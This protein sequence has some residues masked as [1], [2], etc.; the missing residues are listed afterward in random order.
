MFGGST[1]Y[2]FREKEERF[3][4]LKTKVAKKCEN[5]LISPK[6]FTTALNLS[7]PFDSI[8]FV[9]THAFI[10]LRSEKTIRQKSF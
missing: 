4:L 3:T 1:G 5:D 6:R 2:P 10:Q 7:E 8:L 9:T